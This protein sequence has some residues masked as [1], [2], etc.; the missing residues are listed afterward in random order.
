MCTVYIFRF[1][2]QKF[3]CVF[4][5]LFYRNV[6]N[7][8]HCFTHYNFIVQKQYGF[9]TIRLFSYGHAL[10][11]IKVW[12]TGVHRLTERE[13][14][15]GRMW[16]RASEWECENKIM[17]KKNQFIYSVYY[18]H[19]HHKWASPLNWHE[20]PLKWQNK[21]EQK[22]NQRILGGIVYAWTPSISPYRS[23]SVLLMRLQTLSKAWQVKKM[24]KRVLKAENDLTKMKPTSYSYSYDKSFQKLC[25]LMDYIPYIKLNRR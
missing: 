20:M 25:P 21:R 22:C 5:Q 23:R 13:R 17:T 3:R 16:E 4:N 1:V 12:F 24:E 6:Y 18:T 11:I 14:K 7:N 15:G 2:P 9:L 8:G 10:I 19:I